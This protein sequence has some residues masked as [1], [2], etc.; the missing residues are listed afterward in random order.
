VATP[1][2]TVAPTPSPTP[3]PADVSAAFLKAVSDPGFTAKGTI[4]GTVTLGPTAGQVTGVG[5]FSGADS[6]GTTT[7]SVGTFKQTT[8]SVT[9]GDKSWTRIPPGPWLEDEPDADD[10][11]GMG[12]V[13]TSI[14]SVTDLGVESKG[15]QQLHHLQATGGG[16]ITADAVGFDVE[17]A[18]DAKF[19]LDLYATADGT[20]AIMTVSGSWT[21]GTGTTALPITVDFDMALTNVGQPQAITPPDTADVWIRNESTKLGYVMAHPPGWTVK[22]EADSDTYLLDGQGYVYVV[23]TKFTGTTAAFATELKKV[24]TKEFKVKETSDDPTTLG[25]QAAIRLVYE[26]TNETGQDVTLVD[27][28]TVRSGTGWEVFV[29]TTG[30]LA[31]VEIFDQFVATFKF[32]K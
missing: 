21:Q 7:I 29:A 5:A 16:T 8:D 28:A 18:T 3:S 12:D 26:F 20:P 2:P 10:N 13:L 32:T 15:G 6:S 4:T 19:T 22:S 30:G 17:G 27:D 11:K 23:T 1:S 31:D 25:G 9:V 24:Y 14:K